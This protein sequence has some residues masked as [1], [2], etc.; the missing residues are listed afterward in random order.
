MSGEQATESPSGWYVDKRLPA[1]IF[2]TLLGLA[3]TAAKDQARQDERI[4]LNETSIQ[5][6]RQAQARDQLRT[7]K[8][9]DDMK[10]DLRLISGKLDRLIESINR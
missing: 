6:I 9:L 4:S 1:V 10:T 2:V 8:Q 5:S 7:E 3:W